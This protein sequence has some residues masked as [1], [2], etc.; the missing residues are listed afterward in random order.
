[1]TKF[2][3]HAQPHLSN[4]NT[5][6]TYEDRTFLTLNAGDLLNRNSQIRGKN[7]LFIWDF[8]WN[9]KKYLLNTGFHQMREH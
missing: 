4:D 9:Q 6:S 7:T 5:K 1:L 2:K 8:G 3:T